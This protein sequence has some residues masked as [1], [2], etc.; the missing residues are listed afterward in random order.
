M[1]PYFIARQSSRCG[2][3]LVRA[4]IFAALSVPFFTSNAMAAVSIQGSDSVEPI[5][6][7]VL[8][9]YKRAQPDAV[10]ALDAKGTGSGMTAF[11]KGNADISMA[12]RKMS[13]NEFVLCNANT[14]EYYQIPIG[15]DAVAVI[16]HSASQWLQ[17]LTID[18]LVTLF[19]AASTGKIMQW[20]QVRANFPA[21][22]ITF[23]GLDS[24]SGTA[25]FFST[26]LKGFPKSLRTDM[27]L[28]A[29]HAR[30]ARLVASSPNSIG[31]AS[32]T[33][34]TAGM[35]V[36]I[37]AIDEGKGLGAITPTTATILD[38]KYD[39]LS[40]LLYIYVSKS[41]YESKPDVKSVVDFALNTMTKYV[42]EA[43]GLPLTKANYETVKTNLRDKKTGNT[44]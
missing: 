14:I 13:S 7:E 9:D 30:V 15:W 31:F 11:C 3:K 34:L 6:K 33:G 35:N 32:L 8:A 20:N 4:S 5:I 41:A 17:T 2:A 23:V 28:E 18:E 29:D 37:I 19:E 36:N 21:S 22:K 10:I 40:R 26:A 1:A 24:R 12:S 39:K 16:G 43:G 25:D 44:Q 42:K 27:R 38:G